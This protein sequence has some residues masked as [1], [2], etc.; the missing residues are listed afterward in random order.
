[1]YLEI[2]LQ[3]QLISPKRLAAF[4]PGKVLPLAPD[5]IHCVEVRVNGQLMAVGELVQLED[6]L[7]V[8]LHEVYQEW[9]SHS[10]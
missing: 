3:E 4:A 5:V 2:L 6:R 9:V 10:S 1:M 7:G 8:E